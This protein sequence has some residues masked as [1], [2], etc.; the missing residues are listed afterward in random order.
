MERRDRA[1]AA[2]R[3]GLSHF[4]WTNPPPRQCKQ[5]AET[6]ETITAVRRHRAETSSPQFRLRPSRGG[7][8]IRFK[9]ET[10]MTEV[11]KTDCRNAVP[12]WPS[13]ARRSWV[14]FAALAGLTILAWPIH[15]AIGAQATQVRELDDPGRIAYESQQ[16]IGAGQFA[17]IFS[18]VP[19]GHR[20]VIQHVSGLVFFQSDVS[21]VNVS[22][23]SP[24]GQGSSNFLGSF[25]KNTGQFDQL[26][27][28]YVDAG[29]HPQVNVTADQSVSTGFL[30]LTGYLLD[31]TVA[32]CAKIAK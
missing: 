22:A 15:Q 7:P 12:N 17:F 19:A 24:K 32:P 23:G 31:C 5:P 1:A 28:L 3:P 13:A 4:E 2:S 6:T 25:S 30:T 11:S 18:A 29:D 20:L 27:Q 21:L 9:G 16:T 26:V 8:G 14:V 10:E